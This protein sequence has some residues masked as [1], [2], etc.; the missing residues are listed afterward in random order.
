MTSRLDLDFIKTGARVFWG[1]IISGLMGTL[2]QVKLAATRALADLAHKSKFNRTKI[3]EE[4]DCIPTI[5]DQLRLAE[6]QLSLVSTIQTR[7]LRSSSSLQL[8]PRLRD[9]LGEQSFRAVQAI[10]QQ[11]T[12]CAKPPAS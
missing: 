6:A 12:F 9:F 1:W 11:V 2:I 5:L 8:V 10:L 7:C 4:V 3:A